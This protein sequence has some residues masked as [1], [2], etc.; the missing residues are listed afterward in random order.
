MAAHN[1]RALRTRLL[2]KG[3]GSAMALPSMHIVL[4]EIEALGLEASASGAKST[5]EARAS[6][7]RY[8]DRL[9][10]PDVTTRKVDGDM[11]PPPGWSDE[12]V[13]ASFDAFLNAGAR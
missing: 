11:E 9:Y 10:K 1:W 12:E 13:E 4:D 5:T 2:G 6:I 7:S 3:V 8:H